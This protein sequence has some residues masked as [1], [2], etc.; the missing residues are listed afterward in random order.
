MAEVLRLGASKPEATDPL[1]RVLETGRGGVV[2]RSSTRGR[3]YS[4]ALAALMAAA[5][6]QRLMIL[7]TPAVH[8]HLRRELARHRISTDWHILRPQELSTNLPGLRGCLLLANYAVASAWT[9][10]GLALSQL[11]G[12]AHCALVTLRPRDLARDLQLRHALGANVIDAD[13]PRKPQHEEW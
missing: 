8:S 1:Y 11:L 3:S 12:P 7:D 5:T 10:D 2:S 4:L 6:G 9:R 13:P